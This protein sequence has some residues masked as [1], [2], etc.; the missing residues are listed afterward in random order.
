MSLLNNRIYSLEMGEAD[1][2]S[3]RAAIERAEKIWEKRG[4]LVSYSRIRKNVQ[5]HTV[6][7]KSL[8]AEALEK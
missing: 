7:R 8:I 2:D 3:V 4:S 5:E 1:G 6:V